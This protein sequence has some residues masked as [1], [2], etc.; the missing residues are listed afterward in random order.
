[1]ERKSSQ[2]IPFDPG[3][4]NYSPQIDAQA[5]LNLEEITKIKSIN[6]RKSIVIRVEE[7]TSKSFNTIVGIYYGCVLYGAIISTKYKSNPASIKDNPFEN[8]KIEERDEQS[9]HT[10]A[11]YIMQSSQKLEKAVQFYLKRKSRLLPNLAS[12]I[13]LYLDFT[14][15]NNNFIAINST[16]KV[17]L[18]SKMHYFYDLSEDEILNKEKQL[19]QVINS[20]LLD[21]IFNIS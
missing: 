19:M 13:E 11:E 20:G 1:M 5:L 18:P 14:K 17:K 8:K 6:Q 12:Y 15:L 21:D 10:E 9:M 4:F 16:D 3:F 7:R 2:N